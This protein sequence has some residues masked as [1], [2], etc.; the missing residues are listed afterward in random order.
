MLSKITANRLAE[1]FLEEKGIRYVK[2]GT[3][4]SRSREQVEVI[5][6]VPEALDPDVA[7]VDPPDVRILVNLKTGEVENV[8]Q[9]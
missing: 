3:I 5:F 2:P 1:E 9:M 7:V 4:E 6:L 8:L